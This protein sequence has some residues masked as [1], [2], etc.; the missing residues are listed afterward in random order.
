M[1]KDEDGTT[2]PIVALYTVNGEEK[3]ARYTDTG[4]SD[5]GG[6][7]LHLRMTPSE[8]EGWVALYREC[9]V[10][11]ASETVF[12]TENGAWGFS[13]AVMG[14]SRVEWKE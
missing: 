5:G 7:G 13:V 6:D 4:L 14:I 2:Y 11:Y 12:P 10:V 9:G 8:K 3:I 1:K